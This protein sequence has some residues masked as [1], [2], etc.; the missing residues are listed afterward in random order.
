MARLAEVGEADL[1]GPIGA[2]LGASQDLP[3]EDNSGRFHQGQDL[4]EPASRDQDQRAP[5]QGRRED[6][7]RLC[8]S[9]QAPS[10][11]RHVGDGEREGKEQP[12]PAYLHR[13]PMITR[14]RAKLEAE[15]SGLN[16]V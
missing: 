9:M 2:S 10:L 12:Q 3:H 4:R 8:S 6:G 16:D 15:R 14:R 1:L 13:Y 5:G 11:A 7:N